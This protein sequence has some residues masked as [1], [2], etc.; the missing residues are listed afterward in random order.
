MEQINETDWLYVV[1]IANKTQ[2]CVQRNLLEIIGKL[3]GRTIPLFPKPEQ[4]GKP[5][6]PGGVA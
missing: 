1:A 6:G 3:A 4:R 2:D 5:A